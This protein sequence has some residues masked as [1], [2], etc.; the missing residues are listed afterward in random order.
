MWELRQVADSNPLLPMHCWL[1]VEPS[2]G[3]VVG[4]MNDTDQSW[5]GFTRENA[6]QICDMLNGMVDVAEANF[7][8]V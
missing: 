7:Q 5:L 6:Q 3:Y 4:A 8:R 2:T 1:V